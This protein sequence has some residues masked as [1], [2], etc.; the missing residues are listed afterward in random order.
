M[1]LYH[2]NCIVD[3]A[4]RHVTF[5]YKF[6]RGVATDS[7]GLHCAQA[8]GL[9]PAVVERAAERKRDLETAG[10]GLREMS[11]L[12]LFKSLTRFGAE[13]MSDVDM[14]ELM[15]M[16]RQVRLALGGTD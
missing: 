7:Y 5:L 15:S 11:R 2:M 6:T 8:A 9:P 13:S 1:S 4:A 10:G 12:A 16:R 3:E 14:N